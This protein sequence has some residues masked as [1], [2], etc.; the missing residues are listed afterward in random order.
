[1]SQVLKAALM[2]TL[3]DVGFSGGRDNFRDF[4]AR[5]FASDEP[6]FLRTEQ[7]HLVVFRHA[8]LRAFGSA[9]QLGNV[10]PAILYPG[11]F[12]QTPGCDRTPGSIV[13]EVIANQVFTA[14]PPLHGPTRK[15]L[16]SWLGPKHVALMEVLAR[17]IAQ[18][19]ID[20]VKDGDEVDFVPGIAEPLTTRF[21]SALL[22][23]TDKETE[24]MRNCAH[25]MTLLFRLNRAPED[26]Q[27][28]DRAFLD[29]ASVLNQAAERG[30]AQG[31]PLITDIAGQLAALNFED[32]LSGA[33]IVPKSVG[34]FL[35]GNLVDGF[36]TAALAS[37]NTVYV[38]AR[39]PDVLAQV[40]ASPDLLPRAV[41]EALRLEPPVIFLKRYVLENFEYDGMRFPAGGQIVMLWAAGNHDPRA[42]REPGRFDITRPHQGLTTFGSG[43]HICPGRYVGVMLT[44]VLIETFDANSVRFEPGEAPAAW[45]T[46]HMLCQLESMRL[47]LRRC[48]A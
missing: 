5:I 15:I 30:L 42:F 20:N 27:A 48:M 32:D 18:A 26:L 2:P 17:E 8:D 12:R 22:H 47:K 9:R 41:A 10:P 4:C 34:D 16:T 25:E 24:V 23:L 44:R 3:R 14:N 43:I 33:G 1:M 35:A 38:L 40:I 19:I 39:H 21:W 7:D 28:L 31:D 46:N 36:H 29:Y 37:A 6:R 13:A 45:I 11:R